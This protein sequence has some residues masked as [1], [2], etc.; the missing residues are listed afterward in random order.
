MNLGVTS[1]AAPNAAS[2]RTPR[3]S[4]TARPADP[5]GRPAVPSTRVRSLASAW[6]RLASTAKPSRADQALIDAPLQHRL[7]QA[8][9]QIAVAE[10]AVA[11]LREGRMIGHF[12]VETQST[13]PAIRQ[14]EV[15]LLAQSPLRANAKAVAD[16]QHANQQLR[17]DRWPTHLAVERRQFLP[18]P[19]EF[20]EAIDRPQQVLLRH[21]PFERKLVKQSLLLDSPFPHHCTSPPPHNRSES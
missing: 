3:Y 14:V 21:M 9:Q 20:D 5:G 11:V 19:V 2:S 16:D 17:V 7:E 10:A 13:K 6:I 1:V 18:Q 8:P 4:S 15:H 12:A